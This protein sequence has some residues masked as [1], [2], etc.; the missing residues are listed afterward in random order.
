MEPEYMPFYFFL[1][2]AWKTPY[3]GPSSRC[4]TRC[5]RPGK[6]AN[7]A[8]KS[9]KSSGRCGVRRVA[10]SFQDVVPAPPGKEECSL[11]RLAAL[12]GL[13]VPRSFCA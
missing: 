12:G 5:P 8:R 7:S 1:S 11:E 4:E 9:R 6:T 13:D 2:S 3:D 10:P